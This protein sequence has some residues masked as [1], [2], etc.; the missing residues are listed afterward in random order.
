MEKIS[1]KLVNETLYHEKLDN[2]LNVYFVEKKDFNKTFAILSTNYGALDNRFVP[3]DK[4]EMVE[5]P[6]GI[7]HFLEHKLFEMEG[8]IDASNMFSKFGA[9]SNA[10]T[11]FNQTSYLFST[12]SHIYECMNILLDFVFEP[13]FTDENVEKEKG[14]IAQEIMM[15]QDYPDFKGQYGVLNNLYKNNFIK[16][17]I[18][19]SVES[20]SKITKEML[21]SCY[22][23]FYSPNN[24]ELFVIGNFD[25]DEMLKTIKEN[26]EKKSF[27]PFKPIKK[28]YVDD[29]FKAVK[30]F[31][32]LK[33][34]VSMP[35]LYMGYRFKHKKNN[36][37]LEDLKLNLLLTILTGDSSELREKLMNKN[38][39]NDTFGYYSDLNSSSS[40]VIFSSDTSNVDELEKEL[41]QF[42]DNISDIE[43]SYEDFNR[44]RNAF[45]GR[46]INMINSLESTAMN[47]SSFSFE[48]NNLYDLVE[49]LKNLTLDDLNS[50]KNLFKEYVYTKFEIFPNEEE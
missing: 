6:L 8:G 46:F 29:D 16:N 35:K 11:S 28:E 17:E 15:Y 4:N 45:I 50:V 19:G 34:D 12:T 7:A 32:S 31:E 37:Q 38:L 24:M 21:Y 49:Y 13:Y 5:Y 23:T 26:Q 43:I 10:F 20:I 1:Y 2:G 41:K 30:D 22:Y 48:N 39:I 42:V 36:Y 3:F 18:A 33:M 44:S 9:S 47:F 27:K 40:Y 25:K 14:I